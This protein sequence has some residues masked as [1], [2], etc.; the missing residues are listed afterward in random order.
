MFQTVTL[1]P[2][3]TVLMPL[4]RERCACIRK[5]VRN[6]RDTISAELIQRL[7]SSVLVS[8]LKPTK[9]Q[10]HEELEL[11][12]SLS[13]T[14]DL[15]AQGWRVISTSP[16]V[17]IEF[18]NG[19]S[20]EAEKERIRHVHLIDRDNQL[21]LPATRAFIKGM[22]KRRLTKKGW[23]SIYSVMRDG[24]GLAR[25][26]LAARTAPNLEAKLEQLRSAIKPYIQFVERDAYCEH[27]GLRLQ[28]IW[29]YFRHTW[30]NSYKSVPGRS[31]MILIRDAAAENHPVVGIACLAS[32]VVQQSSRDKWIGWDSES[33]VEHF[34]ASTNPK[35]D[36][37]W[38][39][40]E[41][42]R[43]IKSIYLKDLLDSGILARADLRKPTPQIIEKL[44]KDSE[45]AI[46][47]HRRYPNAAGH[48]HVTTGSVAEWRARAETSLFR[49]KR[50]KQ[51]AGLL[52]VRMAFQDQ[53]IGSDTTKARWT[54][55]FEHARF[56]QAVGQIVRMLKG[57]RVGVN[58][59]D[60]TVCGAV[61]PYNL[62]LGGKLVCLLLCSPEVINGYQHRYEGRTSLIASSMRGAPV[63]RRA[64][65]VLVCTTSLYGSALSQYSRVKV[66]AEAI[67]G[68]PHE[69][70]EYRPIGLSEGFGSFHISQETLG[71]MGTL[72][73]RSKE[74]RKVNSIFGEGVNPLMRKIREGMELLGLPSDVLMNHGNKRVVYGVALAK[75]FR[76]V[77]RG[78]TDSAQYNAPLTR[79]KLRTEM[80]ADF[81]RRR[82][83]LNR[84]EK[85]GIL[86]QVPNH[87]VVYPVRH[88]AQ[89]MLPG[90]G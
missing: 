78:F 29:R 44:L 51:L 48:K 60:I 49:S 24:E 65:L 41:V 39:I 30:V 63:H 42:D 69:K 86:E 75:N 80:L 81:W 28:D 32:S 31:M 66:P 19:F 9:A 4:F 73:S 14:I 56:R 37:A 27:T 59:M 67:G 84:M 26:L 11:I 88:G 21:R 10:V 82:W 5:M 74:A 17:V 12:A 61:A 64:Q 2:N 16:A 53:R 71:L 58:M 77:L 34:R 38:L 1:N 3:L 52:S 20:P 35:R 85:P 55:A 33:A 72:I 15:I 83:L 18:T 22:E 54:Q 89:V 62:L 79:D 57:E 68:R 23:H 25:D 43:F 45:R 90:E 46:R 6:C 70:I 13:V 36:A 87:T 47:H 8:L 7:R 50:A 76:D 40:G